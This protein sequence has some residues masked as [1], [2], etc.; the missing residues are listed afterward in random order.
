MQGEIPET[1]DPHFMAERGRAFTGQMGL[2]QMDRLGEALV[3]NSGGVDYEIEFAKEGKISVI[4]GRVKA[5]LILECQVCLGKLE[6]AVDAVLSLAVVSSLDEAAQLN[7][8]Y[9]P[10]IED[11]EGII[12]TKDIVEDELLLALPI[13]PRHPECRTE[14]TATIEAEETQNPF[15]V[16]AEVKFK[17][18]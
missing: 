1:I 4:K 12:A 14:R 2:Q 10:L 7:G 16:L 3:E 13:I 9:E 8:C 18:D 17:G 11:T 15:A 5:I 6:L